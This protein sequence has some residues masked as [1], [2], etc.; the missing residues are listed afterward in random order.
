MFMISSIACMQVCMYNVSKF[1]EMF[2]NSFKVKKKVS[3]FPGFS[4]HVLE[5]FQVFKSPVVS[6]DSGGRGGLQLLVSEHQYY[7]LWT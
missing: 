3:N 2:S 6:P 7:D 1:Q 4:R 5:C